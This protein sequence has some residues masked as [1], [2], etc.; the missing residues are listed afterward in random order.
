M[1]RIIL[2]VV[3]DWGEEWIFNFKLPLG[4]NVGDNRG[5]KETSVHLHL[6]AFTSEMKEKEVNYNNK[7][8]K[9][10]LITLTVDA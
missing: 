4:G 3:C 8:E 10:L 2:I 6:F 9:T 1:T 5:G 7:E